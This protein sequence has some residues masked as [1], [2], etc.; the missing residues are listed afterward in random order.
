MMRRIF[1]SFGIILA[2]LVPFL[3]ENAGELSEYL[4]DTVK[5][6]LEAVGST[7]QRWT[8]GPRSNEARY[9]AVVTLNDN[10]FPG[11]LNE[12]CKQRE[13]VTQLIPLLVQA[14]AGE[15]VLDFAFT[16]TICPESENKSA[17]ANLRDALLDAAAQIPVVVG[18]ATRTLSELSEAQAKQLHGSPI[19]ENGLILR[20]LIDLP[21]QDPR[22]QLSVGLVRLN[23]NF[24]KVP[25]SWS[26]YD[27]KGGELSGPKSRETLSFAAAKLYRTPFP[28]G[29][30]SLNALNNEGRH[31]LTSLLPWSKFNE[32]HAA[33]LMCRDKATGTL[34]GCT[35]GPPVEAKRKLSGKIVLLGWEDN[36]DDL[37]T[38][39]A[40]KLPG[41]FVQA[42]YIESLL[43]SRYLHVLPFWGQIVLS[44]MWFGCIE[45]AFRISKHSVGKALARA[46]VVFILGAFLFY[47]IA[48]VN[49]GFYLALLPP[50]LLAVLL[51][52]WY[53]WFEREK[54]EDVEHVGKTGIS[55]HDVGGGS[56]PDPGS[57]PVEGVKTSG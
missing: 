53:E 32:V 57:R 19:Q 37:Y 5:G 15:I 13:T 56:A 1:F 31:P 25:L 52:C 20:P 40:G 6:K 54:G 43:D 10:D 44:I 12:A 23:Q 47:Y 7:F 22:Y 41:V 34:T 24:R 28:G 33:E 35:G 11:V 45:L 26:A 42:N 16:S 8:N 46:I 38:T 4:P 3:L 36:R 51:R 50:S 17:T 9:T 27:N 49:L 48:V 55:G 18:Q 14:H 39:P 30:D 29:I 21:L 2:L